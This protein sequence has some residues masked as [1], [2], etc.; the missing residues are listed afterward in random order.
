MIPPK[1]EANVLNNTAIELTLSPKYDNPFET[2]CYDID[3]D[4]NNE[5]KCA[6]KFNPIIIHTVKE[7]INRIYNIQA[8]TRI[9]DVTGTWSDP[10]CVLVSIAPSITFHNYTVSIV[11]NIT[12]VNILVK[13]QH[14]SK[15]VS[16]C[17]TVSPNKLQMFSDPSS[18]MEFEIGEEVA[19][20]EV[21][22]NLGNTGDSK[23][24]TIIGRAV[25]S[26]GIG[27]E[28]NYDIHFNL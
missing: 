27:P 5:I 24:I 2:I 11:Y 9:E 4:F 25:N 8:R 23:K 3:T 28:S 22:L 17:Q 14:H 15:L 13:I 21:T 16:N 20:K 26:V 12:T 18:I 19:E 1:I 7:G 10:F 6:S